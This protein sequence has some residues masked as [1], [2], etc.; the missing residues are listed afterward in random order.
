MLRRVPDSA[1]C[2]NFALTGNIDGL[3]DLF[4]RGLASPK[5]VSSTRGYSILRVSPWKRLS[6]VQIAE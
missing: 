6:G 1:A 5:D 3:K 4:K 2:V